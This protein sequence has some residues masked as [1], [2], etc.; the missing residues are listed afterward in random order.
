MLP[1]VL[2]PKPQKKAC[3]PGCTVKLNT[4]HQSQTVYLLK[5]TPEVLSYNLAW[6]G[7]PLPTDIFKVLNSIPQS[8]QITDVYNSK[9]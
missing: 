2:L 8:F 6:D 5:H 1:R 3:V 7:E 9:D 4:E